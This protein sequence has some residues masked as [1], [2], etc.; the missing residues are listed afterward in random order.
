[1]LDT[2][3]NIYI[4]VGKTSKAVTKTKTRLIAEK[5]NK[6]ERKGKAEIHMEVQD[7]ESA[8]FWRGLGGAPPMPIVV[9]TVTQTYQGVSGRGSSTDSYSG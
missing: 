2:G 7:K 3:V 9:S 8:A 4:W 1:M 5:I 6:N